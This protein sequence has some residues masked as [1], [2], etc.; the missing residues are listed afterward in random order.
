M[1][2]LIAL[3]ILPVS[4]SDYDDDFLEWNES[5]YSLDGYDNRNLENLFEN[6]TEDNLLD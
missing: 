4:A 2:L 3:L 5:Y 6:L 1:L